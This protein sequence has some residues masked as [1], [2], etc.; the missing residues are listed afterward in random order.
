[1][2]WPRDVIK[3]VD[4]GPVNHVGAPFYCSASM[5][6]VN[7]IRCINYISSSVFEDMLIIKSGFPQITK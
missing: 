4:E 1:M 7:I 6:I 3:A 2:S 5:L